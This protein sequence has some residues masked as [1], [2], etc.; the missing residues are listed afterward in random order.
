VL[1]RGFRKLAEEL[2]SKRELHGAVE[3]LYDSVRKGRWPKRSI[4]FA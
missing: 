2:A 1:S 4:R 3:T